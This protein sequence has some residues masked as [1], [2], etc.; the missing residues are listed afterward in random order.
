MRERSGRS[1]SRA[2]NAYD[3]APSEVSST[4]PTPVPDEDIDELVAGLPHS[5]ELARAIREREQGP[6]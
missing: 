3:A 1:E 5:G 4:F 6:W 2:R